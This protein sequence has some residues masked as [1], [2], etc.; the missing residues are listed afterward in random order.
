MPGGPVIGDGGVCGFSVSRWV[1]GEP[2]DPELEPGEPPPDEGDAAESNTHRRSV[3][4]RG[5]D[6]FLRAS[7]RKKESEARRPSRLQIG[8]FVT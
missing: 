6:P 5:R 4:E 1:P 7:E 2:S 8:Q 3:M